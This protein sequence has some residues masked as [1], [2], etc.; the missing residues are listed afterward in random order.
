MQLSSHYLPLHFGQAPHVV[1]YLFWDIVYQEPPDVLVPYQSM[2]DALRQA[3]P[4]RATPSALAARA[5][6]SSLLVRAIEIIWLAA[7]QAH[8]NHKW[9]QQVQNPSKFSDNPLR[10]SRSE[11]GTALMRFGMPE[12]QH[13]RL[14]F[15]FRGLV[16]HLRV[17][18]GE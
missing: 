17:K 16:A 3:K 8:G 1:E 7:E 12:L 5:V 18:L 9:P 15:G 11:T 4:R 6:A 13:P 14:P 10:P 2:H